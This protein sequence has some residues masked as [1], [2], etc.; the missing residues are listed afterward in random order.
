MSQIKVSII[1]P[2]YNAAPYLRDCL[3]SIRKQTYKNIEVLIID[4]GSID[5]SGEICDS[6]KIDKRFH[7]FHQKNHG[8]SVARNLGLDYATG[9]YILFV[10][11]DDY[12]KEYLIERVLKVVNEYHNADIVIFNHEEITDRG[13]VP[14]VQEFDK[15]NIQFPI[16]DM[17]AILKL[18]LLDNISN[19]VWDKLYKKIIWENVRFPVGY[20]YED[21]FILPRVFLKAKNVYYLHE[22]LYINNRTNEE[23]TTSCKNDFSALHRYSKFLAYCEHERIARMVG[24]NEAISWGKSHAAHEGIK[25]IYINYYSKK[26]LSS[27][28]ERKV[29]DYLRNLSQD[30]VPYKLGLKYKFLIWSVI[31]FP[32]FCKLY[33]FIRYRRERLKT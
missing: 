21:L 13:I 12:I 14:F 10:D 4:D 30:D 15:R 8:Q 31:N 19:L 16:N 24:D 7:V 5:E 18:V 3:E 26:N 25:S 33:G 28:E 23:S 22:S 1:I 17:K 9:D 11:A 2:V 29:I 20:Y 27:E 6:Y 32:I